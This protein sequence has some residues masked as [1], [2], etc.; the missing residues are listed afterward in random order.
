M[1]EPTPNAATLMLGPDELN[2]DVNHNHNTHEHG[3]S[4]TA[5]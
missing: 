2:A 3:D 5:I 1:R 4:E